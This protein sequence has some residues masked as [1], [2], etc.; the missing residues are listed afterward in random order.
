MEMIELQTILCLQVETPSGE[1]G[2]PADYL[3]NGRAEII[4]RTYDAAFAI[5]LG[6][7]DFTLIRVTLACE[8]GADLFTIFDQSQDLMDLREA[9][10]DPIFADFTAEVQQAFPES[11]GHE[12]ILLFRDI[13]VLPFA[14]G[15][16]VGL[17]ALH[18]VARDWDGGC[19]L[20]GIDPRTR[21]PSNAESMDSD[22]GNEKLLHHFRGLGFRKVGDSPFL[23]R[24]PKLRQIPVAELD[25]RNSVFLPKAMLDECGPDPQTSPP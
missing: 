6:F 12:D 5:R 15:Q 4:G 21:H 11:F 25:V 2:D 16:R 9:L 23:L 7:V 18:R 19:S 8:D 10:Y 22:Q 14:R 1:H 13:E 17:S 20:M 24:S 3:L